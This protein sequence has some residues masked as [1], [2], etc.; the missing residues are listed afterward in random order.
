MGV[1]HGISRQA[2]NASPGIEDRIKKVLC[3]A[4]SGNSVIS[5]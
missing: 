1:A 2:I 5:N 3:E 4:V